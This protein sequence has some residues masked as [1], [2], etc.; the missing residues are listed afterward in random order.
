MAQLLPMSEEM[1]AS[2]GIAD[3]IARQACAVT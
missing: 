2:L 3:W 1:I